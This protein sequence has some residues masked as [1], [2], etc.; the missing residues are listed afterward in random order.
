M[1]TRV[2]VVSSLLIPT[3]ASPAARTAPRALGPRTNI[4]RGAEGF[5]Q[6]F[7]DPEGVRGLAPAAHAVGGGGDA[8]VRPGGDDGPGVLDQAQVLLDRGDLQRRGVQHLGAAAFQGLDQVLG[9]PVRGDA[10]PE[11]L[12][13][14]VF[15]GSLLRCRPPCCGIRGGPR[16]RR[17]EW[18][19]ARSASRFTPPSGTRRGGPVRLPLR[20]SP[21]WPR[22]P[23][24]RRRSRAPRG[25]C[26]PRRRW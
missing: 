14:Q 9:T 12:Q 11:A 2:A 19:P 16:S 3:S 1:S 10:D 21:G 23:G 4:R 13:R 25:C 22:P 8:Q 6:L 5:Q 17:P 15:L 24:P 20:R 26:S 18:R 7:A